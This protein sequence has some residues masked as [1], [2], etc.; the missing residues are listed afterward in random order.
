MFHAC[1]RQAHFGLL[2]QSESEGKRA[3]SASSTAGMAAMLYGHVYGHVCEPDS[4]RCYK[5]SCSRSF[6]HVYTCRRRQPAL[7]G[8]LRQLLSALMLVT[9]LCNNIADAHTHIVLHSRM[10]IIHS[11]R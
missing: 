8:L 5:N 6:T 9:V 11:V 4:L 3:T 2:T 10:P 7:L 1:C